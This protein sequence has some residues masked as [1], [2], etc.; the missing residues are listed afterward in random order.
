MS[1][2]S[3]IFARIEREHDT[4]TPDDA[5]IDIAS[6]IAFVLD[7]EGVTMWDPVLDGVRFALGQRACDAAPDKITALLADMIDCAYGRPDLSNVE[8]GL[9]IDAVH[10]RM[11][12][13]IA[14][15]ALEGR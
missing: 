8:W 2:F 12:A 13:E 1:E 11:S 4:M 5:T 3:L 10:D 7:A 9:L 14:Q 15:A 6:I